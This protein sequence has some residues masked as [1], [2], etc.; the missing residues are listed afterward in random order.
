MYSTGFPLLPN[1]NVVK[2][3]QYPRQTSPNFFINGKF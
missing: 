3:L 1:V 2:F